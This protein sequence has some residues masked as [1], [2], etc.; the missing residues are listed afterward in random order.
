M[1]VK[2]V[3]QPAAI[4]QERAAEV[5]CLICSHRVTAQ[6][7]VDRRGARVKSGETC[8]RCGSGLGAGYVL[9]LKPAA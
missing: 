5:H 4:R 6:V 3:E 1:L 8:S 2:T 9:M 7:L